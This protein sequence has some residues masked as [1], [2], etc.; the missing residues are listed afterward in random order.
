MKAPVSTPS[1][2]GSRDVRL[3]ERTKLLPERIRSPSQEVTRG[4]LESEL[5]TVRSR[6]T[7]TGMPRKN[8]RSS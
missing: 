2:T 6:S 5:V 3:R 4:V 8:S 1:R 7:P